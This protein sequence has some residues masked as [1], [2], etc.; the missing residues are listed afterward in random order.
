[1]VSKLGKHMEKSL[2]A[3][4]YNGAVSVLIP[5]VNGEI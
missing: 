1:M 5:F 2:D 3:I 4:T